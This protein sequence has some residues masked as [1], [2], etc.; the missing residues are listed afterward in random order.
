MEKEFNKLKFVKCFGNL[1]HSEPDVLE[2]HHSF[3]PVL[4]I[5]GI[6]SALRTNCGINNFIVVE[7]VHNS[8]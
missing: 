5:L 8:R 4:S 3:C 1:L 2:S 7:S 6:S